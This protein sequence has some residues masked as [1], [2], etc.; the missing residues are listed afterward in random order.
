M[1]FREISPA[2]LQENVFDLFAKEAF[3]LT[4][5]GEGRINTMTVG[6]GGLGVM[7][8]KNVLITMVRPERYTYGLVENADTFSMAVMGEENKKTVGYC[9]TVSGRNEDKIAACGLTVLHEGETPYFAQS[10][11]VFICKKLASPALSR[12]DFLGDDAI[13]DRWYNEK[14][15]GYHTM[16]V[17]EIVK[18]LIRE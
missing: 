18:I 16:F 11:V 5:E 17:G 3:L 12:R 7:W 14:N 6:W 4:A 1:S 10:R 9:G 2:K 13:P 15:G 8:G